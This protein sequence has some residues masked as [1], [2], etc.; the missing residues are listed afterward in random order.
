MPSAIRFGSG[1][2][3]RFCV[4]F[5]IVLSIEVVQPILHAPNKSQLRARKSSLTRPA[6]N[7]KIGRSHAREVA[8]AAFAVSCNASD[9][10]TFV[11]RTLHIYATIKKPH[12]SRLN[13]EDCIYVK[14]ISYA[15]SRGTWTVRPSLARGYSLI[16][17]VVSIDD[18]DKNERH[19]RMSI[20]WHS[21]STWQNIRL[22]IIDLLCNAN[23]A[24]QKGWKSVKVK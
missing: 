24:V 17:G 13:Y 20:H 22:H 8:S 15:A 21:C 12:R 4:R 19:C 3:A 2:S 16:V 6:T 9:Q 1:S 18:S 5:N 7:F 11:T 10:T 14:Q 23:D